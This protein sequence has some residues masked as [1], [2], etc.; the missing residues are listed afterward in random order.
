VCNE[1]LDQS[2]AKTTASAGDDDI[3]V[4]EAHRSAPVSDYSYD[5]WAGE[6]ESISPAAGASP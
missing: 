4:F 2:Q 5:D 1:R 3:L 6:K